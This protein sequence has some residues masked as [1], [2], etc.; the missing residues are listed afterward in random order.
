MNENLNEDQFAP[1]IDIFTGKEQQPTFSEAYR[2]W[3]KDPKK[4]PDWKNLRRD[5][6]P[7]KPP[8][9]D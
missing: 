5:R 2:A 4:V 3:I 1:V 6:G 9:W 7:I 8:T